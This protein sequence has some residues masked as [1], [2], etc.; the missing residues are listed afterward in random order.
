MPSCVPRAASAPCCAA[1]PPAPAAVGECLPHPPG[2]RGPTPWAGPRA[3]S[4]LRSAGSPGCQPGQS[5]QGRRCLPTPS[6][7]APRKVVR[8]VSLIQRTSLYRRE[9]AQE[10]IVW[11]QPPP[12]SPEPSEEDEDRQTDAELQPP[13]LEV[14]LAR[15]HTL[16]GPVTLSSN[17][18]ATRSGVSSTPTLVSAPGP[19][20][21]LG[22]WARARLLMASRPHFPHRRRTPKRPGRTTAE[23]GRPSTAP[24]LQAAGPECLL[25]AEPPGECLP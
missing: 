19:P 12:A 6:L 20:C 8:R 25:P 9:H 10:A 17:T 22:P 24:V 13:P 1:A 21:C 2:P 3:L 5:P 7:C 23:W 16:V 11:Q 14:S 4:S 18:R 15:S